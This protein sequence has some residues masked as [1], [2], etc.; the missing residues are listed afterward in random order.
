MQR[1]R[2]EWRQEI[3]A[4]LLERLAHVRV[5]LVLAT[6]DRML[7]YTPDSVEHVAQN[8]LHSVQYI[9]RETC[10]SNTNSVNCGADH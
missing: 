8:V 4:Q 9:I 3:D 1:R 6:A 2:G 5:L 7:C 10:Q